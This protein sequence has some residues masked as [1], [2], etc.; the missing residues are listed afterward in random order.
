[1]GAKSWGRNTGLSRLRQG[2]PVVL[3]GGGPS[4]NY[5]GAELTTTAWEKK[6]NE[7]SLTKA[8]R[9]I[10]ERLRKGGKKGGLLAERKR[11]APQKALKK[12]VHEGEK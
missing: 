10:R 7:A 9:I 2:R 4:F 11:S 3:G 6:R 5:K 12:Y 8:R 1:M